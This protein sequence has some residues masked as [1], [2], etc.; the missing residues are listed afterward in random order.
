M[1]H[2]HTHTPTGNGADASEVL[3]VVSDEDLK[4]EIQEAVSKD[5]AAIKKCVCVFVCVCVCVVCM[6]VQE[7]VSKGLMH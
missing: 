2:P 4:V 7:A 6:Y 1:T 3:L 5:L